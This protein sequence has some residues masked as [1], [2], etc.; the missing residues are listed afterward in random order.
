ML[1]PPSAQSYHQIQFFVWKKK[2]LFV[3]Q[4]CFLKTPAMGF[5]GLMDEWHYYES[6][7]LERMTWQGSI[8]QVGPKERQ[9]SCMEPKPQN[10]VPMGKRPLRTRVG[11]WSSWTTSGP[12]V[13]ARAQS[14]TNYERAHPPVENVWLGVGARRWGWRRRDHAPRRRK[15]PTVQKPKGVGGWGPRVYYCQLLMGPAPRRRP[16]VVT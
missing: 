11:G 8:G 7:I 2:Y 9:M 1:P 16:R 10:Y 14:T 6:D 13:E 12:H 5:S 15:A 4:K 3:F